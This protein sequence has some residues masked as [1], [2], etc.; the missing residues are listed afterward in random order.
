MLTHVRFPSGNLWSSW[1]DVSAGAVHWEPAPLETNPY[2]RRPA[3][4][5]SETSLHQW[6]WASDSSVALVEIAPPDLLASR[7]PPNVAPPVPWKRPCAK[8]YPRIDVDAHQWLPPSYRRSTTPLSAPI[9]VDDVDD[10]VFS[11]Q[12]TDEDDEDDEHLRLIDVDLEDA[13]AQL[14][15]E[16]GW[17]TRMDMDRLGSPTSGDES[18]GDDDDEIDRYA[19]PRGQQRSMNTACGPHAL[20]VQGL[21]PSDD[22]QC[23]TL[24]A[25]SNWSAASSEIDDDDIDGEVEVSTTWSGPMNLAKRRMSIYFYPR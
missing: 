7:R 18:S 5:L 9:D 2:A 4:T 22:D 8:S 6:W 10:I 19:A 11:R 12:A 14:E 16:L 25:A 23:D 13:H 17:K 20:E 21:F 1:C 3:A 15:L 24:R